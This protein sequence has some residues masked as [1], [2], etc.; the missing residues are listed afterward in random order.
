MGKRNPTALF[1]GKLFFF[2]F[3]ACSYLEFNIE[4]SVSV[5]LKYKYS[6]NTELEEKRLSKEAK[7]Y[8]VI[9]DTR[10]YS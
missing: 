7:S 5:L 3:M 6:H 8:R 2:S 9:R 10:A 1:V 4:T